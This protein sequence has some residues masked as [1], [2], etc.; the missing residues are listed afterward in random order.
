VNLIFSVIISM[1]LE[2]HLQ[3]FNLLIISH[4]AR[5]RTTIIYLKINTLIKKH[6][7]EQNLASFAYRY[8]R[9]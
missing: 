2:A 6:K 8:E 1:T 7:T 9:P 3:P 4:L 5:F